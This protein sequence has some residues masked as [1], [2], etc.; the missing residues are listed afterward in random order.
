MLTPLYQKRFQKDV[1]KAKKQG[2]NIQKLKVVLEL[3]IE[4]KPLP[5]KYLAHRLKGDYAD[6][7][8]CH[9]E[10]DWLLIYIKTKTEITF[11]RTGSYT[12]LFD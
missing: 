6:C 3:L 1:K 10:P 5:R 11:I 9:I 2:K 4:E 12:E 7:L 8:E